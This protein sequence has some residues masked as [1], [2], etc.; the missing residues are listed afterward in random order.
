MASGHYLARLPYLAYLSL[1]EYAGHTNPS[2]R[3]DR[4]LEIVPLLPVPFN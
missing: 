1:C 3:H 4:L 2:F